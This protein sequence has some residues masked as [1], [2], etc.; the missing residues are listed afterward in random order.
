MFIGAIVLL[1]FVIL[2]GVNDSIPL[3]ETF[4]LSADISSFNTGINSPSGTSTSLYPM[5]IVRQGLDNGLSGEFVEPRRM[6][7]MSTVENIRLL[8]HSI[9][10]KTSM[11]PVR[12]PN[13][14][15]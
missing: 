6:G 14:L 7:K 4:F 15:P 1:F 5:L 8:I 13:T 2:A 9:P 10:L 11:V 3:N 12:F